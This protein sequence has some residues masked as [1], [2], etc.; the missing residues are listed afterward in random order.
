MLALCTSDLAHIARAA[1]VSNR[2]RIKILTR[3]NKITNR[4]SKSK[5][6]IWKFTK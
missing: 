2:E 4:T 1:K 5:K 6:Y 3:F